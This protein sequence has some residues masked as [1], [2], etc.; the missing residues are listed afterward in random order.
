[1][2]HAIRGIL[3]LLS[4]LMGCARDQPYMD[5]ARLERGM[6]IVLPGIEGRSRYNEAIRD[7]LV[8]GG[9]DLAIEIHD[10]TPYRVWTLLYN[11]RAEKRNRR[12]A[13]DI[14]QQIA[15]YRREHPARPV[16]VVGQSGGGAMSVF[17]AEALPE[18]SEVDGIVMLA[19]AISPEYRL[20]A[21]LARTRRGI[22]SFYSIWDWVF[23]GA[24]TTVFGTVD[25]QHTSS[26]GRVGFTT[27]ADGGRDGLYR[28]LY[29]LAWSKEMVNAGHVG[30]HVTSGARPYV[31]AYVAPLIK[32]EAWN[33]EL[34]S[35]LPK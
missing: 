6:V 13:A 4:L 15:T 18:G 1:M 30:L 2:K 8:D 24:G 9:V 14:A 3:G 11:L 5:E 32:A 7:G 23:C 34:I 27:P 16:F 33:D 19:A 17:V 22:V 31:A 29:Q 26:A 12:K 35:S 25:G 10:W 28:K 21:A 20:E